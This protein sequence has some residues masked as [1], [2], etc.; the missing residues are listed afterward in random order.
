MAKK[1]FAL[2]LIVVAMSI[3][4]FACKGGSGQSSK[5][6]SEQEKTAKERGGGVSQHVTEETLYT[7]FGQPAFSNLYNV[8]GKKILRRVYNYEQG[9][10]LSVDTVDLASDTT[11]YTTKFNT[12]GKPVSPAFL[13]LDGDGNILKK[14]PEALVVS[15]FRAEQMG[16]FNNDYNKFDDTTI[17]KTTTKFSPCKNCAEKT[18]NRDVVYVWL[19][20]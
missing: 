6:N 17:T 7:P 3:T 9:R 12:Y 18:G 19:C 8:A 11:I 4:N 15:P 14:G 5:S 16:A 13:C 20:N 1:L 2:F 10:L